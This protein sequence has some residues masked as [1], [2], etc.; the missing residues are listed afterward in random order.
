[1]AES[2]IDPARRGR[3]TAGWPRWLPRGITAEIR[4]RLLSGFND[5]PWGCI[6]LQD[7][8]GERMLGVP[9]NPG[10]EV[11]VT[12]HDLDFY[13]YAGLGGSVGAGQ[14]YFLGLWDTDELVDLVRIMVRNR[15]L[16]DGMDGGLARIGQPLYQWF[17]RRREN[18]LG[19][20]R[21]NIAAH[22]DLGND[23]FELMLDDSMM[24]SSG[25]YM[26]EDTT[27][28]QA[29]Q[30]KLDLLCDKL[31][32]TPD[33][34]L[35]EIGTGWGGLAVHA[36]RRH[37][38]RVTTTTIS[39]EQFDYARRR[40][41]DAGLED[42]IEVLCEDYRDL[43]GRFD[44]IISVEMIEAVGDRYFDLYF[45][46]L[47][48]LLENDGMVLLQA[49]TIEDQRYER[50]RKS[51]D[52]IKRFV[53]P[54]GCLP[55]VWSMLD[56]VRRVTNLRVRHLEDIG[57]HYARTLADWRHTCD[58]K[59]GELLALGYPDTFQRLWRFYLAYCEG[60]FLERA[61]GDVQI[62]FEKPGSR[63]PAPLLGV[64]RGLRP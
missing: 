58:A 3:T 52:F 63:W 11:N 64:P 60:G 41:Q 34:H 48:E 10:P 39:R 37:G 4:A 47:D 27:L 35:L 25:I 45:R 57:E 30:H 32:L 59:A 8:R 61:I 5:L 18:S 14:S 54:G 9:S 2:I 7:P 17:H 40:V 15:E 16:L 13:I 24:Y 21:A 1:M 12:V 38:C 23:F 19:G 28:A 31:Q 53:F 29:Q 36:A 49:I 51:V 33:V 42:R 55:S 50:Y 43:S 20:S 56:S 6:R 26:S 62:L 44:R 46:R 22:Y